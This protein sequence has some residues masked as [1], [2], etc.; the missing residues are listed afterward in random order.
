MP[1]NE[2]QKRRP[3]K[4]FAPRKRKSQLLTIL[5]LLIVF[6]ALLALMYV[7]FPKEAGRRIS[8]SVYDGLV[9]S[10]VMAANSSAV[11]DENGEFSDWMEI[12]NGTGADL[13]LEGVMITNRNDRITFPFP[14]YMLKA[15]EYVIVFA[16]DSYQMSP[17]L[18]FHGKFKIA[19]VGSTLYLYDPDMY[20]IDEVEVPTMIADQS[21]A[22]T[23]L[24]ENGDK[25][26]EVTEFYSP[27]YVNSEEGFL[28]YRE[29]NARETGDLIIN[30]ICPDPKVGIPDDT[31]KVVDWVEIY[32]N[33]DQTVSL[34]GFYLSDKENKPLKWK[35]PDSA[36][37]APYGY[38]LVFCSG[39]DRLQANGI[40]H[41]NF[42]ISAERESVVLSDGDGRLVDRVTIENVPEDY[43]VGLNEDGYWT[44]F[45][46]STP[47]FANDANGQSQ[48]DQLI[49]YYNPTGVYITEAMVSNDSIAVGVTGLTTDYLELYNSSAAPVD[50]A[51][52][53][54][55]DDLG[56]PRKWQF[57]LGSVIDP[58][59]YKT[60]ILDG[61]AELSS[62]Y[63][64]HTNFKLSRINDEVLSFCDPTGKVLDRIPIY[65][66]TPT[67][68]SFG[69]SLGYAGFYYYSTPTPGTAN[70]VGYYGYADTPSFSQSGGEY[71]GFVQ[72]TIEVP[73]HTV[74]YYTTDGSIPTENDTCYTVGEVLEFSR[75]TPL[76]ARA[77]DI[78]GLLQASN[79]ITQT[80]FPNVYHTFP[81]VSLVTDPEELWSPEDGMLTPGENV[82]KSN[83]IPFKNAIYREYG[84]IPREGYIE[85]YLKDGTQLLN[86]GMEFSLQG[87]YSLDMPQKTFKVKSKAKYGEKYFDAQIFE[88]LPFTQYKGIVLR[89]SGNDCV[90]TRF[91]DAFQSQLIK[92][93]S[94]QAAIP[95]T[96][97]YQEWKP[98]VVY[99]NGQYWGH[100]N[101]RERA[102][103]FFIVQHEGYP[104]EMADQV[105]VLEASSKLVNG[106]RSD[107]VKMIEKVKKS[108]PGTNEEDLQYI[109][110]NIDVDNY[111]DYMA[112]EMFF[113]NSDT[114]NIRFYRM[115][116]EGAKWRWIF[117]DSDY[118][119][120][121][122]GFDSP[123]SYLR[124]KGAGE[125]R[126]NNTLIV[127]LLENEQMQNKFLAR[128][129]EIYQFLT[130]EKMLEVFNA[131]ADTLEPEMALHFSRWAEENDKAI[132]FDSPSTPEGALRYWNTRMD[133]SRNV[134][135]K[136][137]TYFYEMIQERLSLSDETM[138]NYFGPKPTL[139]DDAIFTEG[140]KWG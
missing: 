30:E 79:I 82:D 69:R 65:S 36:T 27:G 98:V 88:S 102:D 58:G 3:T 74:V 44:F 18:P 21:Y 84:K 56:R 127:K 5:P 133:R 19:S 130:T 78:S 108:S 106:S 121:N 125:Q 103:R 59:E 111:F 134:I 52:Y 25:V 60:I 75:A 23:G 40:P 12:Y 117:Y 96:V 123:T 77:F 129:G 34:S 61:N 66:D 100:Y 118:G 92:A 105:D 139:P 7:I 85:M 53:G 46:L 63:E 101:L 131:M 35:F 109:L 37:I 80:Y 48:V 116:V 135:R 120:F 26:Y 124:E 132:N 97:I 114:G 115:R 119:M 24:A 137:P 72:I 50:L 11:P 29:E 13:D 22:L 62:Y 9:I 71:K 1:G 6:V 57:P 39:E 49:R 64:L 51:N 81:I 95:T 16:T 45:Q 4:D 138:L 86:Q 136:R 90:W 14:S 93:F 76:R 128:L 122:S 91:N 104:L 43:S 73:E 55:S 41:T 83:G 140:K 32:N 33:T 17:N 126:I 28:A 107:Y 99:L 54:L 38:Y 42:S 47:G 2:R 87:Q 94:E 70:A 113:G 89:N 110:D 15:G 8:R 112:F 67:D 10:E 20:L 68:H 31:G